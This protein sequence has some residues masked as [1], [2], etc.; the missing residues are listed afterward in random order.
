MLA[1]KNIAVRKRKI[2]YEKTENIPFVVKPSY[3][4]P[5]VQ[6]T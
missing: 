6:T 2:N 1:Q 3:E 5:V 4:L